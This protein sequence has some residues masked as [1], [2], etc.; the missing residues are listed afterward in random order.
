MSLSLRRRKKHRQIFAATWVIALALA[1][2]IALGQTSRPPNIV[3]LVADDLGYADLGVQGNTDIPTPFIDS[4]AHNGVRFTSGYANHPVCSPSRAGLLTG[5]YQH[6]FGFEY[7]SGPPAYTSPEFGIPSDVPILAERLQSAGYRTAMIGKWHVGFRPG[8]RP[9][10]RGFDYFY[11]FLPG[12][13]NYNPAARS[14]GNILLNGEPVRHEGYLTDVFGEEAVA[15]IK[16]TPRDAPFFLYLA[17]NAVH[18]PLEATPRHESP[19]AKIADGKRRTYAGMLKAMDDAVGSVLTALVGEGVEA[20]TLVFFYSDNGGPTPQTTSRNDPLRGFKGQMFEGGIR[21]PFMVQWKGRLPAAQVNHHAVMSFDIYATALAAAGIDV[22]S[23]TPP[24]DGVNLL[25][26]LSGNRD[27]APHSSL[28]W[29]AG[30]NHAARVDGYKL[31]RQGRTPDQLFD[32]DNDIG[33]QRD[34]AGTRP[35]ELIRLQAAYAAWDRQMQPPRWIRQDQQNAEVGGKLKTR[36]A[37]EAGQE[38]PADEDVRD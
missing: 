38:S 19:F 9:W 29:R 17:F 37:V 23:A 25:P 3:V 27:G 15:F 34:L 1:A 28:F 31:V 4:I 10:E 24:I 32:L 13:M 7:N 21:V 11:G 14:V 18:A 20:E 35:D 26:Y 2:S 6:R 22:Q 30:P 12:A 36:P 8:L 5:M 33:E 16:R